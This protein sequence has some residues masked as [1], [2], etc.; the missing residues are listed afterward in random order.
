MRGINFLLFLI[1]GFV[2]FSCNVVGANEDFSVDSVLLKVVI[3]QGEIFVKEIKVSSD[4]DIERKFSVEVRGLENFVS[5]NNSFI[6]G[7]GN[8]VLKVDFK[9]RDDKLNDYPP[10]IYIGSL[11]IKTREVVKKVPLIFEIQSRNVLFVTNLD[12]SN[13]CKEIFR[14][15]NFCVDVKVFNLNDTRSHNIKMDYFIKDFDGRT[16]FSE[17]ENFVVESQ[18][19]INKNIAL[20]DDVDFGKYVFGVITKDGDSVSTSSYV[21]SVLKNEEKKQFFFREQFFVFSIVVLVFLL[22][23]ILLVV[24]IMKER[25]KLFLELKRIHKREL[26]NVEEK[27]SMR[28]KIYLSKVKLKVEKEKLTSG[29]RNFRSRVIEKVKEK[30]REQKKQFKIIRKKKKSDDFAKNILSKW[31]KEG[32]DVDKSLFGG[33]FDSK[34][35]DRKINDWRRGGYDVSVLG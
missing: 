13:G 19:L 5:V 21:F 33:K 26:E 20:P 28:E 32:Y 1:L 18:S 22:G 27:I 12:V 4:I 9:G 8:K 24:Y 35:I 25:D 7:K 15:E 31:R 16:F 23:I 30:H 6:L 3:K 29:F 11:V 34:N 2:F 17:I 10:G 14:G